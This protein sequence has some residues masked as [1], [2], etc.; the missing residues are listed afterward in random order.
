ME[1]ILEMQGV[2]SRRWGR[3]SAKGRQCAQEQLQGVRPE[4]PPETQHSEGPRHGSMPSC[5]CW[6]VFIIF[7]LTLKM[8]AINTNCVILIIPHMG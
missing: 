3:D 8:S 1:F 4:H 5:H 6:K 7:P 2:L